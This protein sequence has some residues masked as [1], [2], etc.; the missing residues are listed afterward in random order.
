VFV[1]DEKDDELD[2]IASAQAGDRR[3]FGELVRLHRAAVVGVV[4]RLCGDAEVAEDA[5]QEAFIRAWSRLPDYRPRAPFRHWLYRIAT[6]VARDMLRREKPTVDIAD[7]P[8]T[9]PGHSPESSVIRS[10]RAVQI[11]Q[12]VLALPLGSRDVLVL[13]E[14]EGFSYKEIAETLDIPIGTVMSRL[15]YARGIL[16]ER[17]AEIMEAA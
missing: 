16:R 1:T 17:L 9:A 14:Y 12:A 11:Q 10:D 2:L 3:A 15:N 8:L 5:A 7:L 4:F 6:N 13:R